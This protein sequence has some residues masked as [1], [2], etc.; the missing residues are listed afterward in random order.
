MFLGFLICHA[1]SKKPIFLIPGFH[2]SA[3]F[4]TI[5]KPELYPQCPSLPSHFQFFPYNES[6]LKNYPE[7]LG[8]LL[9]S[10][11]DQKSHLVTPLDGIII[12]PAPFGNVSTF[13]TYDA[14]VE[15]F[16]SHGYVLNQTLFGVN[17]DWIHLTPNDAQLFEDLKKQIERITKVNGEKAILFGHSLG[18]YFIRLLLNKYADTNWVKRHIESAVYIAPA[19]YGCEE[20]LRRI[21]N[22]LLLIEEH[23]IESIAYAVRHMPTLYMIFDNP[24]LTN[25]C[26]VFML[27]DKN[28][29]PSNLTKY[30]YD[31]NIFDDLAMKIYSTVEDVLNEKPVEPPVPSI[32]FYNSEIPTAYYRNATVLEPEYA[33]GDGECL[34]YVHDELCKRFKNTK[35]VNF[36]ANDLR[37]GHKTMIQS[38]EILEHI[39]RFI[40][41]RDSTFHEL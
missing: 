18:S 26:P 12:E 24:D 8:I 21:T 32:L 2:S 35:C 7:C 16:Q 41:S 39:S 22:G 28:V 6:F 5:T 33:N 36:H 31:V 38:K 17:Y 40:Q 19:Y 4:S 14:I 10:R 15:L 29:T 20:G 1:I 3:L 11:Y 9:S 25:N 37:L 23:P 27:N 13:H 30:L 34:S